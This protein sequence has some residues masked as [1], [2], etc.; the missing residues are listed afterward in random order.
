MALPDGKIFNPLLVSCFVITIFAVSSA[1]MVRHI[2]ARVLVWDRRLS[3]FLFQTMINPRNRCFFV[4]YPL[5]SI[6]A[7]RGVQ[8]LVYPS[9]ACRSFF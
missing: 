3:H 5:L 1:Q 2:Q 6:F 7:V 4:L 8:P 9:W